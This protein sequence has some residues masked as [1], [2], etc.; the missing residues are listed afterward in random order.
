LP[1]SD[2]ESPSGRQM[3]RSAKSAPDGLWAITSYFN[4][5]GY[6]RR[7]ANYRIFRQHLTLPL[8]AVELAFGFDFELGEGDA[9]ILVQLRG[10]DALWQKERLLNVALDALPSDCR[11]VVWV[12]CDIVFENREWEATTASLLDRV[13]LVQPFS[14][15]HRMPPHWTPADSWPAA[16]EILHSVPSLVAAGTLPAALL[17]TPMPQILFSPG[18][19]WAADREFMQAHGL[20]DACVVGGGDIAIARAAYGRF[21]DAIRRQYLN[22]DHYLAWADP[23]HRAVQ[24]EV[25]F[26]KGN[27]FHLWH[28]DSEHRLYRER[29]DR[30]APFGFNPFRDVSIDH[31]GAWRWS[32]AKPEMHDFV[33][34]YFASR[35]ED[36]SLASM[37][38]PPPSGV[39]VSC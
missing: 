25:G 15:I 35:R 32:S 4:P 19:A 38:A 14:H 8:V 33:L 1:L 26:A 13:L 22:R 2:A 12:D 30:F 23:F 31:G 20:Y 18:H 10:G 36:G 16:G 11:K 29:N 9:D 27:I 3:R 17:G 34:R 21:E 28:G 37:N 39:A 5:I 7:L 6:R 24:S